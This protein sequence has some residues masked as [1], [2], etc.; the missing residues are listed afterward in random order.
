MT[1][2][3]LIPETGRTHQLRVHCAQ[4]LGVPILGDALYGKAPEGEIGRL[5]LQ[6][7]V[8]EFTHPVTGTH[9]SFE[10]DSEF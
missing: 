4:G 8:L 9:L 5:M 2:L 6:A 10:L 7:R 3:R 1:R